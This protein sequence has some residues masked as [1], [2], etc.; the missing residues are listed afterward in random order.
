MKRLQESCSTD[1]PSFGGVWIQTFHLGLSEGKLPW[2]YANILFFKATQ[3]WLNPFFSSPPAPVPPVVRQSKGFP[4]C[5]QKSLHL[6]WLSVPSQAL[7]AGGTPQGRLQEQQSPA[8]PS[9]AQQPQ[10]TELSL[11]TP[12]ENA[13]LRW[14]SASP[15]LA[16]SERSRTWVHDAVSEHSQ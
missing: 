15:A 1:G 6:F 16:G 8:E 4:C 3:T 7:A 13:A 12:S 9:R 11:R 10:S 5:N 14:G 2:R